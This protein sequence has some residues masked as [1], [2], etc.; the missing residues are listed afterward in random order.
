MEAELVFG[1]GRSHFRGPC[2]EASCLCGVL[3]YSLQTVDVSAYADGGTHTL[4]FH[5]EIFANNGGGTNFFL[6]NVQLNVPLVDPIPPVPSSCLVG[7]C[8]DGILSS[9]EYCDDGNA[10]GG[11]GCSATCEVELLS[12]SMMLKPHTLGSFLPRAP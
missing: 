12:G 11:D 1:K 3:G 7:V 2:E 9:G 5:S 10:A 4:T 8:G 6:D